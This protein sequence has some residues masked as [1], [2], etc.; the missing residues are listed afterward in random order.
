MAFETVSD[1]IKVFRDDEKDAVAPY[2]WS[3]AQLVRFTNQALTEFC[4]LTLSVYDDSSAITAVDFSVGEQELAY[5]EAII[6]VV[7]A[8][9]VIGGQSR[10]LDLRAPGTIPRAQWPASGR[11]SMLI[12]NSSDNRMLLLPPPSETGQVLLTVVRSPLKELS[13]DDK[14]VDVPR[15]SRPHLLLYI[16][17]L[18]YLVADGETFDAGKSRAFRAE[19]ADECQGIYERNLLRRAAA[20]RPIRPSW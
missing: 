5:S 15:R 2:F 11:P 10:A 8:T 3:D 16:K 9:V 6:D 19:F 20:S 7:D 14:L 4:G 1:L 17:H 13:K 18:A 12:V